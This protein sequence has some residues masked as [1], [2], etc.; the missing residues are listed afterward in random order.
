LDGIEQG[1][2]AAKQ[3]VSESKIEPDISKG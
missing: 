3:F 2:A 1:L